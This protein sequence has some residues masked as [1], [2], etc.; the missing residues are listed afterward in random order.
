MLECRYG[1]LRT[2]LESFAQRLQG[3][4]D[5]TAASIPELEVKLEKIYP[6]DFRQ[7]AFSYN[8]VATPSVIK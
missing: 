4:V 8:R 2:R 7:L 5:G 3:Y 6:G 1:G